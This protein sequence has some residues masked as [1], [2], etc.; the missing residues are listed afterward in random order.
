MAL[1]VNNLQLNLI[2]KGIFRLRDCYRQSNDNNI[3]NSVKEIVS[4]LP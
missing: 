2:R 3:R 4:Y 1:N